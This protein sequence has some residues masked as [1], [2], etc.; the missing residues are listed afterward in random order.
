MF[1]NLAEVSPSESMKKKIMVFCDYYLPGI[2]GGG[3]MWA[4]FNLVERFHERYE[5]F[6]VTRN[7]DGREDRTPYSGVKTGEWNPV[8]NARAFYLPPNRI[9]PD[10]IAGI[11]REIEPDMV[12]L[13]SVFSTPTISF[14]TARRRK[15]IPAVPVVLASCGEL[16]Q[17]TLAIKRVKKTVYLRAAKLTGLYRGVIWRASFEAERDE[18]ENIFGENVE[19]LIAPDLTPKTILPNFNINEKPQKLPGSVRLIFVSRISRKK[20]L[21]YL[22]ERLFE[23]RNGNVHLDIVGAVDDPEYWKECLSTIESLPDNLTT[24]FHGAV[25]NTEALARMANAHFFILPTLNE[26]FGYVFVEAMAAG[27]A[28]LISDRTVWNQI[29]ERSAGWAIP[30]ENPV[31]WEKC[32]EKLISMDNNAFQQMAN[33]ARSFAVEWLSN[34]EIEKATA[35]LLEHAI[36]GVPVKE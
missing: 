35:K 29:Q 15:L 9:K 28:L 18:I 27:C 10:V 6:I 7:H 3:G 11:I 34:P 36:A 16:A 8:G 14:M 17:A 12:F 32:I 2:K 30:L 24:K 19:I 26:N 33:A 23:I 13:N 5:F 20:N 4:V 31:E 25:S 22:L 1:P 21:S